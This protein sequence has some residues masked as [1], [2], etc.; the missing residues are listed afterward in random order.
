MNQFYP[1][2]D[3]YILCLVFLLLGFRPYLLLFKG[4]VS[5]FSIKCP[6][7]FIYDLCIF[8]MRS[9]SIS[10]CPTQVTKLILVFHRAEDSAFSSRERDLFGEFCCAFAEDM[11]PF[12]NRCFQVLFPP[13][14][15]AQILGKQWGSG[16]LTECVQ[17]SM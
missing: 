14:H 16:L 10:F 17:C 4:A 1:D 13:A 11:V 15:L 8:V 6:Y 9:C 5:E 3:F 2:D 12:L 7:R